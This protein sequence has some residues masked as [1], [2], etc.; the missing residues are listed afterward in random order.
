[1]THVLET[2]SVLVA[3]LI[4]AI[5]AGRR[6]WAPSLRVALGAGIL[7]RLLLLVLAAR[8]AWQPYDFNTDFRFTAENV[9]TRHDLILNIREGGWHF[10]PFTGYIFGG[11]LRVG[12]LLGLP[13]RL[14]GRLAP[15]LADVAL[16][17]LVGKLAPNRAA[18]RR[19]QYAC[20]P[21]ALGVS[22]I[23]AQIEPIALAF[24]VAAFI[25]ARA[26]TSGQIGADQAI[27]D[28]ATDGLSAPD[29]AVTDDAA[30]GRP[31]AVRFGPTLAGVLLGFSISAG[32]WPILLIPGVLRT[33][34]TARARLVAVG[35]ALV[36]PAAF[37]VTGPLIA[38]EE[39]RFLPKDAKELLSTRP[40]VGDWGWTTWFTGGNEHLS[41]GLAKAGTILLVVGLA[42]AGYLW[43][44]ADPIDLTVALLIT[45]LAVTARFGSQYLLWAVPFLI[46]R[47][48]RA[49][50]PAIAAMSAWAAIGYV[51]LTRYYGND[52]VHLHVW[53][54]LV[55]TPVV[56]IMVVAMPWRRRDGLI[57]QP[58][59]SER[60]PV[61]ALG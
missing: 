3:A 26:S 27:A 52:W 48:T 43:R 45:F 18:L 59:S 6:G 14:V 17:P 40:V 50:W 36:V 44:R 5:V 24:G 51:Y 15:M 49:T 53:W 2:G 7:L 39:W 1:V 58:E 38:G 21:I 10:L 9:L 30:T 29:H 25:A 11:L 56:V 41:P 20:A 60:P 35:W 33:L 23:H 61:G 42:T 46:V 8:D 4:L 19:F 54:A 57:E 13:W 37:F 16:I 32:S 31:I 47:P 28:R 12:Q 34:R 22:T 55:S